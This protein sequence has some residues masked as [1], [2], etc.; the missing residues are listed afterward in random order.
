MLAE[1]VA[2][3]S[4]PDVSSAAWAQFASAQELGAFC[5]AWLRLQCVALK[6]AGCEPVSAVVIWQVASGGYGPVALW[7]TPRSDVSHLGDTARKSLG[8]RR[9]LCERRLPAGRNADGIVHAEAA[10]PAMV[11]GVAVG[12]AVIELQATSEAALQRALQQ[13]HWG[14]GWLESRARALAGQAAQA[15][16]SRGAQA[17]DLLAAV[18]EQDSA[19]EAAMALVN[20]LASRLAAAR[21]LIGFEQRGHLRLEAISHVAWFDRRS[22]EIARAENLMEEALDQGATVATPP[23]P[24]QPFRVTVAHDEQRVAGGLGAIV[25]VLL[26]GR[27]VRRA[28]RR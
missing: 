24:D 26:V 28:T 6:S 20:D 4:G 12:V 21:V 7:P 15:R 25:T 16:S 18:G 1:T 9:G 5:D 27:R 8:E 10:Y 11:D 3:R 23:M 14:A 17:L 19:L 13:M 22:Q 2:A